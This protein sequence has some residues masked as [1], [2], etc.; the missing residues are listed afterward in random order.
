MTFA[1]DPQR[2]LGEAL[3][4]AALDELDG[5]TQ[6]LRGDD[7]GADDIHEMRK[8]AKKLRAWLR[9]LRPELGERYAI[10]NGLLRDASRRLS[11]R[12]DADVARQTLLRLRRGR[13]LTASQFQQ[14]DAALAQLR[15]PVV[16]AD[17]LA[18]AR[19]LLKAACVYLADFDAAFDV[20]TLGARLAQ[21]RARCVRGL[22]RSRTTRSPEDL[23][24]WRKQVKYYGYQCALVAPVLPQAAAPTRALKALGETLGLHHDFH[25]FAERLENAP[26][27]LGE[28]L[29]LR[30][31]QIAQ[32]RMDQLGARAVA[33]GERLF[34]AVVTRRPL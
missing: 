21:S 26:A 17:A 34:G 22:R 11:A 7:V 16:D 18:D 6:H 33:Q 31:R 25:A 5:A 20:E 15:P 28:L 2:P 4:R 1:L 24:A 29:K 12:R 30:A 14:L 3:R 32:V 9:L 13:R 10:L 19:R 27:K 23:H 8:S